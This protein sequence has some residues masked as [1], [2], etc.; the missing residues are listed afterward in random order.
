MTDNKDEGG[1][2]KDFVNPK[3]MLTPG[4]AGGLTMAITNTLYAQFGM[5][6][7]YTGLI[8]SFLFAL[9]VFNAT[10]ISR[11]QRAVYFILNGLIIFSVAVGTNAVGNIASPPTLKDKTYAVPM[12]DLFPSTNTGLVLSN[13]WK[14]NAWSTNQW[15]DISEYL[16]TNAFGKKA[17]YAKPLTEFKDQASIGS[18]WFNSWFDDTKRGGA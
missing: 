11:W 14:T 16:S 9:I 1:P 18:K 2:L 6:Q 8:L 12:H 3:S 10:G 15:I 5:S 7:K 17:I 13:R 4:V